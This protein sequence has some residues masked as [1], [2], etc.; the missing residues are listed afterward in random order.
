[1]NTDV[2]PL[3]SIV[4]PSFHAAAFIRETIDSVLSQ[5]Y[6]LV[7]H[8]VIDGG[9]TDGT[10]DILRQYPH[11]RWISESDRGQ[12]HALNKGFN[13]ARGALIGWLNADDTYQP[14]AI[15]MAVRYLLQHPDVDVIYSD[16]QV[17]D[18]QSQAQRLIHAQDFSPEGILLDDI[19]PQPTLFFRRA[20][21]EYSGGVNETLHYV[22]DWE[23]CIRV[24]TRFVLKKL[25]DVL[26]ANFRI[27][28]GTKTTTGAVKS[29]QEYLTILDDVL[30]MLPYR[31]L[32]KAIQRRIRNRAWARYYMTQVFSAHSQRKDGEVRKALLR[33]ARYDPSWLTNRGVVSITLDAFL[34]RHIADRMRHSWRA[35]TRSAQG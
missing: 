10:V 28:A 1:M 35:L 19:I 29:T 24:A 17:I 3:V 26:L 32:S 23:W 34:G 25:P 14:G 11:L 20:V 16:C 33:A 15:E 8:I 5:N 18:G 4:T 2:N 30:E 27:C 6:P 13:L 21:V 31:N 12:S 22:M 7:E 9:S